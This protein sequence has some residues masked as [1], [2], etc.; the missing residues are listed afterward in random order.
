MSNS[1][2][3]R[4]FILVCILI[5][6]LSVSALGL[7]SQEQQPEERGWLKAGRRFQL[8]PTDRSKRKVP[9]GTITTFS[10][11]GE[12][13]AVLSFNDTLWIGTDGGLFSYSIGEDSLAPAQ[14]PVSMSV[15]SIMVDD[16]G[17]L[18]IGGDFGL[19]VRRRGE[20]IHYTD[21]A[22]PFIKRIRKIEQGDGRLWICTY[23]N[24]CG[25]IKNN[26]LTIISREDSL[27]D[28][29]V[30]AV[31]EENP[32]SIWFATASG[33]CM[34]DTL[35]WESLRYGS[36]I[37]LGA[38]EDILFDEEGNL[39]LAIAR[40]GIALYNFGRVRVFGPNDGL[41]SREP[42]AFSLDQLGRV[43]SACERGLS[44]FDGSGWT[45]YRIPGIP[46]ERYNFIS[47]NHDRE[48]NCY[49]G[50]DEGTV[51]ILSRDS[52]K[53]IRLP[54]GIPEKRISRIQL[55]GTVLWFLGGRKLYRLGDGFEGIEPP[56]EWYEGTM[57][58]FVAGEGGDLWVASRFGI[59]HFNGKRWEVFD[60]RQ[61]LP[62]ENVIRVAKD[63]RGGLWFGTFD[64]G[65]LKLDG[66]RWIHYT[67]QIGIPSNLISDLIVDASGDPWI[68]TE[69]GRVARCHNGNW[70][71]IVLPH[72]VEDIE[73]TVQGTDSITEL[74]PN[75]R[76]M[77]GRR[78][79]RALRGAPETSCLGLDE[80]GNCIIASSEGIYRLTSSGWHVIE[81]PHKPS[82][83]MTTAVLGTSRG[84]VWLGTKEHGVFVR[85]NGAWMRIGT[86]DGLGDDF[87][88]SI[89]ED[90]SG[91]IWIGT[92]SGG[93]TR[94]TPRSSW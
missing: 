66:E 60:R 77:T 14:G 81:V 29:R 57:M 94:F 7:D 1:M 58:D 17:A 59:L 62:T 87:V 82:S 88:R 75:V 27:L 92:H 52:V 5:A 10:P 33:L 23:G 35:H 64:K 93:I 46:L 61:G 9:P 54:Q 32:Y 51:L 12:V 8:I 45:P 85:R 13:R 25:Y 20:W 11:A 2:T 31:A 15:H 42:H 70:E 47:I 19:S 53:E 48:G 84:E 3:S 72:Q 74:G 21:Q 38:V 18:W 68:V 39:F 86:M 34:A 83:L 89:C 76:F 40:Q 69:T 24:G 91:V 65:I 71:E 78:E 79:K 50:T 30:M 73:G 43:W 4:S 6:F 63:S 28:D 26:Y 55:S 16:T 80:L 22:H 90:G 44:T 37:P 49:L 36:R 67:D 41:P 56:S